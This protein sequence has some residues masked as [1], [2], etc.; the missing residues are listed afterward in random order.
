MLLR[1]RLCIIPAIAVFALCAGIPAQQD[2]KSPKPEP[3]AAPRKQNVAFGAKSVRAPWGGKGVTVMKGQVWFQHDD[4][5]V[6]SD[7]VEYDGREDVKTAV[8]PGKITIT[9][10]ECDMS[11]DKGSASFIKRLGVLEGNV[12]MLLKPKSEEKAPADKDATRARLKQPTTITCSRLEYLYK[13]KVA[14]AVGSVVFTQKKRKATADKAVYDINKELLTLVGNVQAVDE[15]GQTFSAPKAVISLKK[16]D[17]WIDAPDAKAT[18][19][20]DL[21]EEEDKT[22]SP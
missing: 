4:T 20:I 16:G 21:G 2:G 12:V 22:E 1:T 19:K 8:S 9:N 5:R 7:L 17:E 13:K 11:G 10:P 3:T 14:T 6:A 15:D 18:F